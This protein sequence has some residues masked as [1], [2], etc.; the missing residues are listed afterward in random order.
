MK[1][2]ASSSA[3]RLIA[4]LIIPCLT[5]CAVEAAEK[6]LAVTVVVAPVIAQTLQTRIVAAGTVSP[7]RNLPIGAEASGLAV[8]DGRVN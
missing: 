1:I 5:A 4:A 7:W 6:L 8:T 3:R 2:F